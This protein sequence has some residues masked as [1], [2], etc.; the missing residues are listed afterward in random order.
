LSDDRIM[1]KLGVQGHRGARGLFPENT[2]EGF[3]AT[4]ALGVAQIELDVGMTSDGV[5][6][7]SH[8]LRLNPDIVRDAAGAWLPTTGPA[9][10]DL[11]YA[12]LRR[13][14][15]GRLRPGSVYADLF[16]DQHP[17][18]GARIPTLADVLRGT[19][20][21]RFTVELKTDPRFPNMTAPPAELADAT[22]AVIDAAAAV[23]RI[24]LESFDWR[25]PRHVRRIRPDIRLAWLTRS[26]TVRDA[27][28]WWDGPT[29]GDFGGSVPR[30]VAAEGGQIWAPDHHDLTHDQVD[31]AREL[32][33]MVLPWTVN[34]PDAMRRLLAWGADGFITDRPD[35]WRAISRSESS[36]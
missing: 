31:E 10:H 15:V 33:L 19:P 5:V 2:I 20:D 18:D 4:L 32:G 21:A 36:T 3:H 7:V 35:L 29:P 17:H 25:G 13:F 22:L 8:D 30:A 6:A 11:T 9:L 16:P 14:D 24:D 26:E 28:L 12:Q 27:A 23:S 1:P 34:E